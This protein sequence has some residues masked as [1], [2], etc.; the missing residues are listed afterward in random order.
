[1]SV[2]PR[3]PVI[4]GVAQ[5]TWREHPAPDPISMC[6]EVVSDAAQDA[7]AGDALLRRAGSLA[8]IDI[9]SRRWADPGALVAERLGIAPAETLRTNVGG[10]GPQVLVS[11]IAGRIAAGRLDAGIVCGA[12]ALATLARAMKDGQEPDWPALDDGCS[13]TRT[14][15]SD[16]FPASDT[17]L[18]ADLIAP[19]VVYPLF[20]SAL[21]ARAGGSPEEHRARLGELW[22]GYAQVA[23][24]N[25]HAWLRAAR[26]AAQIA[27]PGKSNRLVTLP[28]TKLLNSNIQTD[29]AAALLL[30]SVEVARGLGIPRDRWVFPHSAGHA[31]D[32]WHVSERDDLRSSPAARF[33]GRGALEHAGVSIGEID[34]FD[35]YSCFPSAVQIT[36]AELGID[37]FDDE[38]PLTVTGGLTFAGGPGNNYVTHSIAAM[39]ERLRAAGGETTGLVTAVGWYL[40]KHAVGVYGAAPPQRP[41]AAIGAQEAV[42]SQPR[43]SVAVGYAGAAPGEAATVIYD[44]FGAATRGTVSALLD[45]GRRVLGK[46]EDAQTLAALTE[47]PAEGMALMFDGAGGFS[48]AT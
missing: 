44:V 29:Q 16:R 17:E 35:I 28:Y 14:L 21:W 20:E 27:A 46:S 43:R 11:D 10:D 3:T 26:S 2:D 1:M 25:P 30:C 22:A 39:V 23:S 40:T 5:H 4:V 42:D 36:C 8:V 38:R 6:A 19:V 32:H 31:H 34:R 47:R 18:A 9:A 24:S 41:F 13:P 7:G 33:A 45:D 15:G 12:E 37:A 48:L